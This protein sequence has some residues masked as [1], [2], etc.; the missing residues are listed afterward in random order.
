MQLNQATDYSFRIVLYLSSL[1]PGEIATAKTIAQREEIPMRYLL[2]TIR[3][4]VKAGIVRSYRGVDGGFALAKSP[5]DI[6]LLDVVEAVEGP[7]R[8]NRCLK[9]HEY[10]TKHWVKPCPV[11]RVLG[12]IQATLIRELGDHNFADLLAR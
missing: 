3:S 2:K 6:T 10:C 11:H 5:K 1:A 12:G 8:I 9:D 4:L 7:V